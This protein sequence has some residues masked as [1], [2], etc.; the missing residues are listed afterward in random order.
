MQRAGHRDF[1]SRAQGSHKRGTFLLACED[2]GTRLKGGNSVVCVL[3]VNIFG[4]KS[5]GV[6]GRLLPDR[7]GAIK[8]IMKTSAPVTLPTWTDGMLRHWTGLF[9]FAAEFRKPLCSILQEMFVLVARAENTGV[10]GVSTSPNV[11]DEIL[12]GACLL[13]T[14]LANLRAPIRQVISCPHASEQGGGAA[15]ATSFTYHFAVHLMEK[16][17]GWSATTSPGKAAR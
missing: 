5:D 8:F 2:F 14:A 11:Q 15:E 16:V 10:K 6:Q 13:L 9:C 7:G 17:S 1:P 4:G 3:R 12:L